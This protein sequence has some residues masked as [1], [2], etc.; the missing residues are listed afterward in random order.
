MELHLSHTLT[1]LHRLGISGGR[2]S[3]SGAKATRKSPRKSG[4]VVEG[5]DQP[6]PNPNPR[7]STGGAIGSQDPPADPSQT[8]LGGPGGPG[9][10]PQTEGVAPASPEG[11]AE[12]SGLGS[13]QGGSSTPRAQQ[14]PLRRD[15]AKMAALE[16]R[17]QGVG[18]QSPGGG[19]EDGVSGGVWPRGLGSPDPGSSPSGGRAE[20]VLF[21]GATS[22][23]QGSVG[24]GSRGSLGSGPGV[25]RSD[26]EGSGKG[27][28]AGSRSLLGKYAPDEKLGGI[29]GGGSLQGGQGVLGVGLGETD[30]RARNE[31]G[32][33]TWSA[34]KGLGVMG[35]EESDGSRHQVILCYTRH[36]RLFAVLCPE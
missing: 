18:L 25:G 8:D 30:G 14:S 23:V 24:S 16:A 21:G 1:L 9:L 6:S 5:R 3:S 7:D 31:E 28:G 19:V 10:K 17:L 26:G 29:T 11:G 27:L 36:Q 15:E 22:A 12:G 33:P 32:D 4:S 13:D 35:V 34:I 20:S 2:P